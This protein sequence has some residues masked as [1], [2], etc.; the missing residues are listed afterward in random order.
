MSYRFNQLTGR[1]VGATKS[2]GQG[3]KPAGPESSGIIYDYNCKFKKVDNPQTRH[4]SSGGQY[5]PMS[6]QML[7]NYAKFQKDDGVPVHLKGGTRDKIFY[8]STIALCGYGVFEMFRNFYN[9]AFPQKAKE[10]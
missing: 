9:M 6:K 10:E 8:Y 5:S 4:S 3:L 2:V 1:I 7:E